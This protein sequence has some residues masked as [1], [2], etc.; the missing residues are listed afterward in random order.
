MRVNSPGGSAFGS[1]LIR[2]QL[3]M[4]RDKG[5]PVLV[6]M[7]D[8][9]ASG[10]YWIAMSADQ[11]WADASTITGS[12]GVFAMLPTGEGLMRKLGVNTGGYRTTWLAGAYDPRKALD[13][14]FQALVQSGVEHIY[15]DFIGKAAQARKLDLAQVDALAQGRIWTGAQAQAHGLVDHVGSFNDAVEAARELVGKSTGTDK[16]LPIRYWGPQVSKVQSWVQRYLIQVAVHLG[17]G[18]AQSE[19]APFTGLPKGVNA[20][21]AADFVWLKALLDQAQPYGAAAHCLCQITP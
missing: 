18:V 21:V 3:R 10:G 2:D 20:A 11:V 1:E 19:F 12:I 8:V 16:P 9:A 17:W 5:K 7:G 15:T 4:A 13:P 6:S 14:R